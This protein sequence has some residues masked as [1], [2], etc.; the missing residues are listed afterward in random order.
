[1]QGEQ[2]FS[3]RS[4]IIIFRFVKNEEIKFEQ[5]TGVNRTI[6]R[7]KL[8]D[9]VDKLERDYKTI[10]TSLLVYIL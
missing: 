8:V 3:F 5:F 10:Q 6:I 7:Q 9:E 1:M 2:S 4:D